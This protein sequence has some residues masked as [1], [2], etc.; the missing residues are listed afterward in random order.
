M[1]YALFLVLVCLAVGLTIWRRKV[2]LMVFALSLALGFLL[3]WGTATNIALEGLEAEFARSEPV[4]WGED[5]VIVVLGTGTH[6][7]SASLAAEPTPWAYSRILKGAELYRRCARSD[8][9]CRL[10]VGGGDTLGTGDGEADVYARTL[11]GLGVPNADII[12]ENRSLNT[13]QNARNIGDIIAKIK[14][15]KMVLVTSGVHMRRALLYFRHFGMNPRPV[16]SDYLKARSGFLPTPYNQV[17]LHQ[18]LHEYVGILR[19]H[20]YNAL[21]LNLPKRE[22]PGAP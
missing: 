8:A 21:G 9:R 7:P 19:Y 1:M 4:R 12:R 2:G 20:I 11:I 15:D 18:A 10:I 6:R 16:R 17:L 3:G 22:K 14:P 13:F 5:N